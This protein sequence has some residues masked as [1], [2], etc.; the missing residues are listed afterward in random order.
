MENGYCIYYHKNKI[1]NKIYIGLTKNIKNRWVSNGKGY[2]GCVIFWNAICKY[3]WDNF[4]HSILIENL[5]LEEATIIEKYLI[6]KY[7]TT[8]KRYGYNM[9]NGGVGGCAVGENNKNSKSIFQYSLDGDF[10]KEW[11]CMSEAAEKNNIVLNDIIRCCKSISGE[12]N[13]GYKQAGGYIWSY[14]YYDEISPYKGRT[15]KKSEDKAIYQIDMNNYQIVKIYKNI[16]E[17]EDFTPK[18]RIQNIIREVCKGNKNSYDGFYW[19]YSE[20]FYDDLFKDRQ[21]EKENKIKEKYYGVRVYNQS[22][23][24][25]YKSFNTVRECSEFF[26]LS[27]S[28]IYAKIQGRPSSKKLDGLLFE[29]L[30]D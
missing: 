26:N 8:D 19:C 3:G 13:N 17:I 27:I 20:D 30:T 24:N 6:K 11:A 22:D 29:K 16:Y 10:I 23:N 18:K 4:E 21:I 14:N 9:S 12:E 2:K 5:S 28:T 15:I 25:I 7:N 1:N